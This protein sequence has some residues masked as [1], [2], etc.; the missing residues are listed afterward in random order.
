MSMKARVAVVFGQFGAAADP[1]N[2]PRFRFRLTSAGLETI[3]VQHTDSQKAFDFLH[4]FGGFCAVVGASLG[5]MSAIVFAGYLAPQTIHFAGGF[6]PSDFDPSGHTVSIPVKTE[7]GD[8]LITRAIEVPT[9]VC[10]ALCFRNPQLALTGGLGHAT[11][12]A[13]DPQKTKLTVVNNLDVHPGDFGDAADAMFNTIT[14][15]AR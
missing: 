9:N 13:A 15:R 7:F 3:L 10:E 14:E 6:Q 1:Q 5:A 12:V 2:L 8:D 11:Y 4:G